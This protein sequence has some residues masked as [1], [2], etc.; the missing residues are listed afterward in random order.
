MALDAFDSRLD[1]LRRS[2]RWRVAADID[3]A[4]LER[5]FPDLPSLDAAALRVPTPPERTRGFMSAASEGRAAVWGGTALF[6]IASSRPVELRF[7]D[8]SARRLE[9]V[10]GTS[11]W[12]GWETIER[13]TTA[14]FEFVVDGAELGIGDVAGHPAE[15]EPGPEVPRGALDGPH[16]VRSTVYDG[17]ET[18]YWLYASHGADPGT[19]SPVMVWMD[20][21]ALASP[22][23][24]LHYR[25]RAV[26][27]SL[28]ASA[29]I[30]PLVHVLVAPST[31]AG[32]DSVGG[33]PIRS[34]QYDTVSDRFAHHLV[35]E[36]LADAR[37]RRPLRSDAYS[38]GLGG[39]SSGAAAA[40]GVAWY[41][42]EVASR[43]HSAIGSFVALDR[44]GGGVGAAAFATLFGQT[45][46]N[47]RVWLSLGT[48]D[49]ELPPG[50]E[51]GIGAAGSWVLG[52]LTLASAL[53]RADYDVRTSIG[54]AGHN[55]AHAAA[56]LAISLEWLWAG[57]D[58]TRSATNF[59]RR[60]E[61]RDPL[62]VQIDLS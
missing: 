16:V 39:V 58:P 7:A 36:V 18:R 14:P 30:P 52:N 61:D 4:M 26:S 8:R 13:G 2:N 5:I 11:Y 21:D 53:R 54:S 60:P 3:V 40:T 25:L 6:A 32:E 9:R 22:A 48:R 38:I 34:I 41:R 55:S 1:D 56:E 29:R 12:V 42:P 33:R 15:S 19:P 50:D 47:L 44:D 10:P 43:L 45:R 20:G 24:A 17:F 59:R 37:R 31:R 46:R 28:A 23:D 62:R 51:A 27:D 57:Y 49:L 35:D